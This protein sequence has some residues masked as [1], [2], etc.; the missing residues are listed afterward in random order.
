MWVG[1]F[2][3]WHIAGIFAL[4]ASIALPTPALSEAS[5]TTATYSHPV[6]IETTAM[7]NGVSCLP[8]GVC[9]LVSFE[10]GIYA[11]FGAKWEKVADVGYYLYDISCTSL[12]FCVAV[13]NDVALMIEPEIGSVKRLTPTPTSS[14][15]W[16]SVSCS[17][18]Q[19]CAIS[20]WI[21]SGPHDGS[22]VA[23][24]WD[25]YR[26]SS[27]K[28]NDPF[29]YN[30][31]HGFAGSMTCAAKTFCVEN[32]SNNITLQWTGSKWTEPAIMNSGAEN[33]SFSV[34]CLS[35]TFCMAYGATGQTFTWTGSK[36]LWG[37][38]ST[39]TAPDGFVSCLSTKSCIAVDDLGNVETW[40]GQ[41]WTNPQQIDPQGHF[42]A[43][44]CSQA[45]FCDAIDLGGHFV[46]I[47]A[48]F[49][50]HLDLKPLRI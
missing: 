12:R 5:E 16:A 23:A 10:G 28:V 21:T 32:D 49:K 48:G 2:L 50:P 36:W 27:V 46:F 20:G 9:I 8:D 43:I 18:P 6:T 44:S 4:L 35:T 13:G 14:V 33:D 15:H 37:P 34:S 19:F 42:T 26:W 38:T 30:A 39:M 7:L 45:G 31:T 24:T 29:D 41:T 47:D 25:G 11:T 17:S 1:R 40:H 3:R 22:G